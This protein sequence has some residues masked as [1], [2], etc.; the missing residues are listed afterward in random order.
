M[1]LGHIMEDVGSSTNR[2]CS[3]FHT[4]K[5]AL[6]CT[7]SLFYSISYNLFMNPMSQAFYFHHIYGAIGP[8]EAK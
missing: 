3:A 4:L 8:G 6:K 1:R 7:I 2:A 5:Q